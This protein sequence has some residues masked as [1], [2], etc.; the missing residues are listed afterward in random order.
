MTNSTV[1]VFS[2]ASKMMSISD[3]DR[4]LQQ[5]L[6]ATVQASLRRSYPGVLIFFCDHRYFVF[7]QMSLI[8]Y[9]LFVVFSR[10]SLHKDM[11]KEMKEVDDNFEELIFVDKLSEKAVSFLP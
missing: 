8:K 11:V 10:R 4:L 6:S 1:E 2:L 7:L 9:L 3:P 5:T